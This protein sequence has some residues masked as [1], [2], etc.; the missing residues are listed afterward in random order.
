MNANL[1]N[2]DNIFLG[3]GGISWQRT[4]VSGSS[5][6]EGSLSAAA[7]NSSLPDI[8][9]A[10]IING[11]S[12]T[13]QLSDF[14]QLDIPNSPTTNLIYF[15]RDVSTGGISFVNDTFDY[16]GYLFAETPG[17]GGGSDI[18]YE[19]GTFGGTAGDGVRLT[20]LHTTAIPEPASYVSLLAVFGLFGGALLYRRKRGRTT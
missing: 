1:G 6:M 18:T 3:F 17:A 11:S 7:G 14:F 12:E 2:F 4:S 20:F 15:D 13:T 8:A 19:W 10:D 5:G 16:T 9:W